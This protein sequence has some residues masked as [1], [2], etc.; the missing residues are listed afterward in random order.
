MLNSGSRVALMAAA[1]AGGMGSAAT[2]FGN[3]VAARDF[4]PPINFS[5]PRRH[6]GYGPSRKEMRDNPQDYRSPAKLRKSIGY[7]GLGMHASGRRPIEGGTV[8]PKKDIGKG[9]A[10]TEPVK[11][12]SHRQQKRNMMESLRMERDVARWGTVASY[13]HHIDG[14]GTLKATVS[15]NPNPRF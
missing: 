10:R 13:V 4:G 8:S 5:G 14:G 2:A 6:R 3:A 9:P 15:T 1:L 12:W 11:R 7:I